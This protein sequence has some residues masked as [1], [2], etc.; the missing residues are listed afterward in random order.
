MG[1]LY[2]WSVLIDEF[3]MHNLEWEGIVVSESSSP[4]LLE[5]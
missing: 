5:K 2:I 4:A 1:S 3:V